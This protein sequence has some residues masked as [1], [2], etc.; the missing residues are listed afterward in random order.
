MQSI[1]E[2]KPNGMNHNNLQRQQHHY[3][4]EQRNNLWIGFVNFEYKILIYSHLNIFNNI[5]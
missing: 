4:K 3:Y 1:K 5:N 2:L